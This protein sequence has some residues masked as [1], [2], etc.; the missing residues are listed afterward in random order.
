MRQFF[1]KTK[2]IIFATLSMKSVIISYKYHT[3]LL[4]EELSSITMKVTGTSIYKCKTNTKNYR[5][6]QKLYREFL[7]TLR[8]FITEFVNNHNFIGNFFLFK[9]RMV[10]IPIYF[11]NNS[12]YF[13]FIIFI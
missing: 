11:K 8:L 2:K 12:D 9:I 5:Y 6:L 13:F 7:P 4:N 3:M 10:T 1:K